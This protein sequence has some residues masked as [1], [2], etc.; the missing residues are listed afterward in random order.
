[1]KNTNLADMIRALF[2]KTLFSRKPKCGDNA[3]A[4]MQGVLYSIS[5][6]EY[7]PV[8]MQYAENKH[9]DFN[10]QNFNDIAMIAQ[11]IVKYDP[12][13]TDYIHESITNKNLTHEDVYDVM[14]SYREL[15]N[16]T[17]EKY[18][19]SKLNKDIILETKDYDL[20]S[21]IIQK[22]AEKYSAL[23]LQEKKAEGWE[24]EIKNPIDVEIAQ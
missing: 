12:F 23:R 5:K 2:S 24:Y 13:L 22:K 8:A 9:K 10:A 21:L 3:T 6:K 18:G 15:L 20:K 14:I 1:M 7:D 17:M 19:L 16:E 11:T 4:E